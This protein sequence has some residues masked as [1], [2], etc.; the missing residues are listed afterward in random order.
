M[1]NVNQKALCTLPLTIT[2]ANRQNKKSSS[3]V[4]LQI[5]KA[6]PHR[7]KLHVDTDDNRWF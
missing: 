7:K 5:L 4:A 3:A 2:Y 1:E 6:Q